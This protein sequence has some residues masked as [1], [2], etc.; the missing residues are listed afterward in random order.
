MKFGDLDNVVE[1]E[2]YSLYGCSGQ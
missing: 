1:L 2:F